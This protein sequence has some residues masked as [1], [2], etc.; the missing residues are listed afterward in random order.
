MDKNAFLQAKSIHV[1][2]WAFEIKQ[3]TCL[4]GEKR[5]DKAVANFRKKLEE[6]QWKPKSFEVMDSSNN[7][8]RDVFMLK[9]Y[10]SGPTEKI[11]FNDVSSKMNLRKSRKHAICMVYEYP[12]EET[13]EYFYQ[14]KKEEK[15]F[16]LPI[17]GIELHIYNCGV[18][19]MFIKALNYAYNS[20]NDIKYINDYG[21]R[22]KVAYV[23]NNKG[24]YAIW[25]DSVGIIIKD[26]KK[27]KNDRITMD[28]ED[29][30]GDII[31]VENP[32]KIYNETKKLEAALEEP[33]AENRKKQIDII[34]SRILQYVNDVIIV[35]SKGD[36]KEQKDIINELNNI[37]IEL[38]KLLSI[39]KNNTEVDIEKTVIDIIGK[40]EKIFNEENT[41]TIKASLREI[42]EQTKKLESLSITANFLKKIL[43]CELNQAENI[44]KSDR[45][46]NFEITSYSD[47]RMFLCSMIRDNVLSNEVKNLSIYEGSNC[48]TKQR[49]LKK[50]ED[51][52]YS[53]IY[54]DP[55]ES[56]CQDIG[57][58]KELLKN[59][60][61][62]RWLDYGSLYGVTSYS[63]VAITGE[64]PGINESVVRPFYSEYLYLISLVL[65]QR[66]GIARFS[67]NT[68]K[69]A[70]AYNKGFW[71]RLFGSGN[72]VD[73]QEKYV[74]F[75]NQ[76][77]V[78]E[79]TC[80][81]QGI[82]MYRL[83]QKQLLVNE[84]QKVL[85]S[86]LQSLYEAISVW[87]SNFFAK[88]GFGV[89][90]FA[91]VYTLIKEVFEF[92][93]NIDSFNK[94]VQAFFANIIK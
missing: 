68:S 61:Y 16:L 27:Q 42:T 73:L 39:F 85:D 94:M 11:F 36:E 29:I 12:F 51:K 45:F 5:T 22:I 87:R 25:S 20:M 66:I 4:K 7:V 82:E 15:E 71:C 34:L 33:D 28:Y 91:G 60:L 84:E 14:I 93:M 1:F 52:V 72:H 69:N 57:M 75:K 70:E 65:A 18:G 54:A 43:Y 79:P 62:K 35:L 58:R 24:S 10:L 50:L 88:L 49:R 2:A 30:L 77:L 46:K 78:L 59:A 23:P 6:C 32:E 9:Q 48:P 90:I 26:S 67:N 8:N 37:K 41:T 13:K 63:Y 80:Q 31:T 64:S 83:L 55:N 74:I 89:S 56:T 81:E 17:D 21:R 38:Q 86:Q 19:I 92:L 3:K 76:I 53:I 40:I 47:D 44:K